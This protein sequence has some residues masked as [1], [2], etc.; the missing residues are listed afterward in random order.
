MKKMTTIILFG[1]F[2]FAGSQAMAMPGGGH[3]GA[4]A[5]HGYTD[6]WSGLDL[7]QEQS[8]QLQTLK[9]DFIKT[10]TPLQNQ[11]V[12]LRSELRILWNTEQPAK[13][14]ILAKE[15][16]IS[17]LRTRVSEAATT[18]QQD[19]RALL[20]PDQLAQTNFTGKGMGHGR[21]QRSHHNGTW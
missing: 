19:C 7:T 1:I 8:K 20:T 6:N 14:K 12:T 2:L 11:M 13:E 4:E 3:H 21:G 16:E 15:K 18:Y 5:G 9:T 10:V 17:D